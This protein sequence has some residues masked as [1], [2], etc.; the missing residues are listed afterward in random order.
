MPAAMRPPLWLASACCA[1]APMTPAARTRAATGARN[2]FIVQ[3]S[4]TCGKTSF[5]RRPSTGARAPPAPRSLSALPGKAGRAI[6]IADAHTCGRAAALLP[7]SP[8]SAPAGHGARSRPF[9][10]GES[11]TETRLAASPSGSI[12]T[13]PITSDGDGGGDGGGAGAASGDGANDDGAGSGG[14]D[15]GGGAHSCGQRHRARAH[16]QCRLRYDRHDARDAVAPEPSEP[17]RPSRPRPA[18]TPR[19]MQEVSSSLSGPPLSKRGRVAPGRDRSSH[20]MDGLLQPL[21]K[22]NHT[23]HERC[24]NGATRDARIVNAG[25]TAPRRPTR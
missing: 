16:S 22:A 10:Q 23:T 17:T 2:F 6:A 18:A 3:S 11:R 4:R 13:C 20:M 5:S 25:R 19:R 12:A 24:M 21:V 1:V 14:A 8:G 9:G 15:N 7:P